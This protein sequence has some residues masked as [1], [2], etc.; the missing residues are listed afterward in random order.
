MRVPSFARAFAVLSLT[1]L[2]GAGLPGVSAGDKEKEKGKEAGKPKILY[3][4]GPGGQFALQLIDAK[5]R[6][7]PINY[8]ERGIANTLVFIS[9][10][11]EKYV[12]G[13]PADGKFPVGYKGGKFEK[14]IEPLSGD[15]LGHLSIWTAGDK[16]RVT[17]KV[18]IVKSQSGA[19][20][21]CVIAYRIQNRAKEA[22]KIG[23]RVLIDTLIGEND[24]HPF[25]LPGKKE[26]IKTSAD[27][28]GK[29]V[30]GHVMALE[31]PDADNPGVVAYFTLRPG[32][33]LAGPD[34]I[35]LT[36]FPPKGSERDILKW[37]FPVRN[38]KLNAD[39][40]GD[41]AVVMYWN[42]HE[43]RGG[44]HIDF[45]FAYGGGIVALG[46]SEKKGRE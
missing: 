6:R 45:G 7:V 24:G 17:Q 21:T 34:R 43:V 3:N 22:H 28:R 37:D 19:L 18:E 29:E 12:F 27:L 35:S 44:G 46:K 8:E 15:R 25:Q 40:P 30:P 11:D 4:L 10:D 16:L 42:P 31:K 36:R 20:D 1:T 33:T 39:D 23:L 38:I 2:L 41:S 5:G 14:R 26:L 9:V 32:G 13:A